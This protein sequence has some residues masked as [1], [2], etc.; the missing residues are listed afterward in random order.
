MTPEQLQILQHTLGADQYGRRVRENSER[1]R[2]VTEA[3][4]RDGLVCQSL[5]ALGFMEDCGYRD[6]FNGNCYVATIAG[7][8]AMRKASPAPSKKTRGELRYEEFLREDCG[9]PFGE[10]LKWQKERKAMT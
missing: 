1:N 2:F 3:M 6:L 5:V 8:E 7:A 10:W 4:C 9:E